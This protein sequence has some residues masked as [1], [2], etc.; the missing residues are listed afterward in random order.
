MHWWNY[1]KMLVFPKIW[2]SIVFHFVALNCTNKLLY[3]L[4]LARLGIRGSPDGLA[5]TISFRLRRRNDKH[6]LRYRHLGPTQSASTAEGCCAMLTDPNTAIRDKAIAL[7]FD[8]VGFAG[9]T[10]EST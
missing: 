6:P 3:R 8:S 1:L 7:G 2:R 5:N 4:S 9:A 10:A